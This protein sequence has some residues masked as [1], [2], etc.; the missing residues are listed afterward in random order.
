MHI[1]VSEQH[2][3]GGGMQMKEKDATGKNRRAGS[4]YMQGS[5]TPLGEN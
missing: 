1:K 3:A 2:N 5:N 4:T